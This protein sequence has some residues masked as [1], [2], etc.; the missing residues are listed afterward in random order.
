M[1]E[2]IGPKIRFNLTIFYV[3]NLFI[4]NLSFLKKDSFQDFTIFFQLILIW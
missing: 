1:S 2:A 3:K 4:K